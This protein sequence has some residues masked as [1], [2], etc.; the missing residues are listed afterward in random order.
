MHAAARTDGTFLVRVGNRGEVIPPEIRPAIFQKYRQ[1]RTDGVARRFGN[2]G[3][4][5]TFC[6]L[7]VER[8]GGRIDA[9]SPYRDG[10]GAAFEVLL[11]RQC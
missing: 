6:R 8:H 7:A 1:G 2:W 11:P 3:L 9:I 5:L 10:E 4:G